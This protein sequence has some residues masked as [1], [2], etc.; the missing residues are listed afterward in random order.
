MKIGIVGSGI[1]GRE[2]IKN[3]IIPLNCRKR[4]AL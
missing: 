2:F 4:K 1:I 3:G